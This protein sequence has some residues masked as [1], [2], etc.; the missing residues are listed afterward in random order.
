[1]STTM[2]SPAACLPGAIQCPG[3]A[4]AN[5]TV[6]VA[7]DR[8]ARGLARSTRRRRWRCPP[9][10]PARRTTAIASIASAAAP[11]GSPSKPVPKIAS[12]T[13]AAS[14]S[15]RGSNGS[16]APSRRRRFSAASPRYSSGSASSSTRT[17]RP[18]PR[19]RRPATRPSPP[20]LPLPQ[21]IAIGPR[22]T[23]RSVCSVRPG[24]GALHEVQRRDAALLDRPAV[25]RAHLLG[26]E[27]RLEPVGQRP[28]PALTR[29]APSRRRPRSPWSASSRSRPARRARRARR[30]AR[31]R[32]ARPPPRPRC[33]AGSRPPGAAPWRPPPWRRSAPRGAGRA[34][35]AR[36]A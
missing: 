15:A 30:A 14:S 8:H 7:R 24:P 16:C 10:R 20:L 21:T 32:V 36:A 2:R 19:S 28:R 17:V 35:R 9:R 25:D 11:R 13:T 3:L 5:V 18:K 29:S 1:M 4:A 22:G 26:A 12:T 6:A 27:E 34:A 23:S 33:R 31:R